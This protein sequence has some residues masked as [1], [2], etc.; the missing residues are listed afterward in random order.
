MGAAVE[1]AGAALRERVMAEAARALE[2]DAGDLEIVGDAIVVRGSPDRRITLRAVA[3]AA[4]HEG[5][6]LAGRGEA[7]RTM[8]PAFAAQ[9]A[10]V[11][12]DTATGQVRVVRIVSA[13]DVGRA[14]NPAVVVGQVHGAVVQGVGYALTE[15]LIVDRETGT[16]LAGTL[17]DYAISTAADV[18]PVDVVLVEDPDPTGPYGARGAGEP[19]IT[20]TAPAIANAVRVTSRPR[21]R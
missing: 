19:A 15:D 3:H 11:E 20:L 1:R 14:I 4:L 12:V 13:Q 10:E 7:P 17:G 8:A 18:P 2:I 9:F 16:V 5:R 21:C 6:E